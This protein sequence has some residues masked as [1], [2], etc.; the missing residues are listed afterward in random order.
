MTRE[1]DALAEALR[2][3]EAVFL[4]DFSNGR[5]GLRHNTFAHRSRVL[6]QMGVLLQ[7]KRTQT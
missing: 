6:R 3:R 1:I 5:V 4:S 2:D 7:H